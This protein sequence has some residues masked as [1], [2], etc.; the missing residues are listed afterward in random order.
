MPPQIVM[1][2]LCCIYFVQHPRHHVSSSAQRCT[3]TA[4]A[5]KA[6]TRVRQTWRAASHQGILS[7]TKTCEVP[8]LCLHCGQLAVN[9][10]WTSKVNAE[11]GAHFPLCCWEMFD[12]S[13]VFP[14][15]SC[16]ND[17]QVLS[18]AGAAYKLRLVCVPKTGAKA[19]IICI[20]GTGPSWACSW[21][22]PQASGKRH[23]PAS[24]WLH[25]FGCLSSSSCRTVRD[26]VIHVQS[27]SDALLG[28]ALHTN[29][30]AV[31]RLAGQCIHSHSHSHN[32]ML[33][34]QHTRASMGAA[35][36]P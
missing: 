35:P 22:K 21:Q 24:D 2:K 7:K 29:I 3:K 12:M 25:Q 30:V 20:T 17:E 15:K 19:H 31:R 28:H 1:N 27:Q 11:G 9:T 18:A 34:S 14:P 4:A 5:A 33:C 16:Q 10:A 36:T 26:K 8:R 6:N 13:T 32:R 23:H